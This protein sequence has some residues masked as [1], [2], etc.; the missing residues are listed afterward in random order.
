MP[1]IIIVTA[2]WCLCIQWS[3]PSQLSLPR[4]WHLFLPV[5]RIMI[6]NHCAYHRMSYMI[7]WWP[8][9]IR[10]MIM[11]HFAYHC[12]QYKIIWWPYVICIM[13]MN[14]FAYH[15]MQYMII[16]WTWGTPYISS[17]LWSWTIVRTIICYTWS[18]VILMIIMNNSPLWNMHGHNMNRLYEG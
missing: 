17:A 8:Y 12:M 1:T 6:M 11:N 15:R 2:G 4:T 10:I 16:W 13:I 18:Y 5:I 14:H 7:I 3:T 9:V